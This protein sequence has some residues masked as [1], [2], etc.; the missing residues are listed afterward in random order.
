MSNE[1]NGF[2]CEKAINVDFNLNNITPHPTRYKNF[3]YHLL[4]LI[5]FYSQTEEELSHENNPYNLTYNNVEML[6][7]MRNRAP[8]IYTDNTRSYDT[9]CNYPIVPNDNSICMSSY[10]NPIKHTDIQIISD[11]LNNNNNND[12]DDDEIQIIP[13]D[14][15]RLNSIEDQPREVRFKCIETKMQQVKD[16]ASSMITREDVISKRLDDLTGEHHCMLDEIN[17]LKCMME[18]QKATI[19]AMNTIQFQQQNMIKSNNESIH[20]LHTLYNDL[21]NRFTSL[22][23]VLETSS[24]TQISTNTNLYKNMRA[25]HLNIQHLRISI[26]SFI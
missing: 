21:S 16:N 7:S 12:N 18:N 20:A 5:F 13:N 23:N 6:N 24:S 2:F 3:I 11:N 10:S 26:D 14:K 19:D 4:H 17:Y 22:K 25:I 1:K 15:K 9:H 8:T